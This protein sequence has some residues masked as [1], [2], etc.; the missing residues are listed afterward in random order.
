MPATLIMLRISARALGNEGREMPVKFSS[1]TVCPSKK[2]G[3]STAPRCSRKNDAMA[4]GCE[5]QPLVPP[6]M[7]HLT[8]EIS[9]PGMERSGW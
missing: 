5:R 4:A 9:A 1:K 3:T 7:S 8:M 6:G 2:S